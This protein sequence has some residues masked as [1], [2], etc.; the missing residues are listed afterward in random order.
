[1][2]PLSSIGRAGTVAGT[3]GAVASSGASSGT[4]RAGGLSFG[5]SLEYVI[6]ASQAEQQQAYLE[7][8]RQRYP[9]GA[10]GVKS[11]ITA[12][13]NYLTGTS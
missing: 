7:T 13:T 6:G 4:K 10:P 5:K 9:D 8:Y 2:V 11:Y 12:A 3:D 1:M